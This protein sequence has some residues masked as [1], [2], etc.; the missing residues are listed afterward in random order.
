[1]IGARGIALLWWADSASHLSLRTWL[2]NTRTL[3]PNFG[4]KILALGLYYTLSLKIE[5]IS[6]VSGKRF[7]ARQ[8]PLSNTSGTVG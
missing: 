5:R 6:T 1:M 2:L 7:A 3:T 8:L 4:I